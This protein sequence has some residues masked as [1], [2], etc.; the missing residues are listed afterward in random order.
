MTRLQIHI[1][2][3]EYHFLRNPVIAQ[4]TTQRTKTKNAR[5][6]RQAQ[7]AKSYDAKQQLRYTLHHQ[8]LEFISKYQLT[9]VFRE[10]FTTALTSVS[11]A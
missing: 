7:V 5:Q 9:I 10:N 4:R 3:T 8:H 11:T 2:R 6:Q 1:V